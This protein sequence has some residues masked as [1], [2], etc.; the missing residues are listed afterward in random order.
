ME[1]RPIPSFVRFISV[2]DVN[3]VTEFLEKYYIGWFELTN[4]ED[5][6][7]HLNKEL[8]DRGYCL[9]PQEFSNTNELISY[10]EKL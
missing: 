8:K 2:T 1:N 3:S 10:Y 5:I 9:I 4:Q 6:L 7:Y